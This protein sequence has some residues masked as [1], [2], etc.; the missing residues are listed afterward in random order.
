MEDFEDIRSSRLLLNS[1][2]IDVCRQGWKSLAFAV[3]PVSCAGFQPRV[4]VSVSNIAEDNGWLQVSLLFVIRVGRWPR[5]Y[6]PPWRSCFWPHWR[7]RMGTSAKFSFWHLNVPDRIRHPR[8][9]PKNVLSFTWVLT[10][11]NTVS[12][13]KMHPLLKKYCW[14]GVALN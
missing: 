14:D 1:D 8:H 13:K 5:S 3:C 6:R 9:P 4:V 7:Y 11:L 12:Q 2:L 10:L